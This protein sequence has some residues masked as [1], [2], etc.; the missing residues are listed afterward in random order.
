MKQ[1]T[2][3]SLM[4][5]LFM[6]TSLYPQQGEMRIA[7]LPFDAV[8]VSEEEAKI[9]TQLYETALVKTKKFNVIERT[10]IES[11]M[12][13]QEFSLSGFTAENSNNERAV[14]VGQLLSA[15][16]ICIGSV[17]LLNET[18]IL[19]VKII[20]IN[21]GLNVNADNISASAMDELSRKIEEFAFSI[22]GLLTEKEIKTLREDELN[23]LNN[24]MLSLEQDLKKTNR[25]LKIRTSGKWIALGAGGVFA[26]AAGSSFILSN[27]A[28]DDYLGAVTLDNIEKYRNSFQTW[29]MIMYA[30]AGLSIVS[31][32]A[33][34]YLW[35]SPFDLETTLQQKVEIS[36]KILN[37]NLRI[38]KLEEVV[39]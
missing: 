31:I 25:T 5:I 13:E 22:T 35:F 36:E 38:L 6:C 28:Y 20:D 17:S 11:V 30:T 3:I 27:N 15:E 1:S 10:R 8:G 21:T 37:L 39:R 7:V 26:A 32:G 19:N 18:Y 23:E 33:A 2:I 24:Q 16:Q 34:L 14:K 9:I 29:D 12:E 4:M